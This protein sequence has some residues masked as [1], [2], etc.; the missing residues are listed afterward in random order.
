[1]HTIKVSVYS[2]LCSALSFFYIAFH[3][4][5]S[6]QPSPALDRH[7]ENLHQMNKRW[8]FL[9]LS[10]CRLWQRLLV[11]VLISHQC[12]LYLC[13]LLF[14]IFRRNKNKAVK[15]ELMMRFHYCHKYFPWLHLPHDVC[16]HP[17]TRCHK[18]FPLGCIWKKFCLA[19][20]QPQI[21][22]R[23]KNAVVTV[24]MFH[25]VKKK[26]QTWEMS[27][28]VKCLLLNWVPESR[29]PKSL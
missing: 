11:H 23:F 15:L 17:C 7:S 12:I 4:I 1:M 13:S 29:F 26:N 6:L 20:L 8:V 3:V 9:N 19:Y 22:K 18:T 24:C 21:F 2:W 16:W 14:W 10:G 25:V 28:S 5:I 27:W